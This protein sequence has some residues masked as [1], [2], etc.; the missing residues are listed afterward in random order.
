M[1]WNLCIHGLNRGY[2]ETTDNDA[3][4]SICRLLVLRANKPTLGVHC[5]Y[6]KGRVYIALNDQKPTLKPCFMRMY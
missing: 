6:V 5:T 4:K 2:N 1:G 3:L